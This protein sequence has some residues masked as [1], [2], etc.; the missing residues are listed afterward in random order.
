MQRLKRVPPYKA[1]ILQDSMQTMKKLISLSECR[2][3]EVLLYN[4]I[5][6]EGV[7]DPSSDW[8]SRVQEDDLAVPTFRD[9]PPAET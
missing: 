3:V 1:Q 7:S 8:L 4:H 2:E 6:R 9:H 5:R